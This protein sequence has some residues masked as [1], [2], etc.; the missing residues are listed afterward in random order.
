MNTNGSNGKNASSLE[1]MIVDERYVQV[2]F[3][4]QE[5][6]PIIIDYSKKGCPFVAG[7]EQIKNW[8]RHQILLAVQRHLKFSAN[9]QQEQLEFSETQSVYPCL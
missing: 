4:K 6:K 5:H 1:I 8:T 7:E 9:G 3:P 2:S